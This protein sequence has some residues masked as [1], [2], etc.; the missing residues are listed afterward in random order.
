MYW[1]G[2]FEHQQHMFR[3]SNKKIEF[4]SHSLSGGL[5]FSKNNYLSE[6]FLLNTINILYLFIEYKI[7]TQIYTKTNC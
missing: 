4:K 6:I 1:E 3:L 5:D 7:Y 2:S